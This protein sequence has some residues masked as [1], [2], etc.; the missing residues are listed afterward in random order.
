LTELLRKLTAEMGV[1]TCSERDDLPS[2][3]KIGNRVIPC[4][5]V[6]GI[7]D[8]HGYLPGDVSY[9]LGETWDESVA[10]WQGMAEWQ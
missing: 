9:I 4:N 1:G 10:V 8:S 6:P 3:A 7:T 5:P 2:E